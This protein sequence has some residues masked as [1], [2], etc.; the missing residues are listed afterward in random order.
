MTQIAAYL[1][2]P[3]GGT[4]RQPDLTQKVDFPEFVSGLI[5]SVFEAIVHGT[6]DQMKEYA[7]LVATVSKALKEF[8]NE[9]ISDSQARD[10]L[11]N[12]CEDWFRAKGRKP[13]ALSAKIRPATSR[14]QLLATMVMMGINRIV[15][16]RGTIPAVLKRAH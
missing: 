3:R 11:E 1:A 6:I 5:N 4:G 14:Q 12:Q 13:K 10:F 8:S 9:N 7:E 15:V 2:A 16:T